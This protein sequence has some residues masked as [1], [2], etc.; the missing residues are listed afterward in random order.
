[1]LERILIIGV[2][3]IGSSIARA[4]KKYNI[5]QEIYGLDS[6]ENV[7]EKSAELQILSDFTVPTLH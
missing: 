2:G 4:I 5:S 3:L 1:M 6:N 7:L